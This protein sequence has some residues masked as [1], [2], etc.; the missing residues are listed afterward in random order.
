MAKAKEEKVIL[1]IVTLRE[2][3]QTRTLST[4][5]LIEVLS[6]KRVDVATHWQYRACFRKIAPDIALGEEVYAL[7]ST[8]RRR[9]DLGVA[10]FMVPSTIP[11]Y[12]PVDDMKWPPSTRLAIMAP[13]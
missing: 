9:G 10:M 5:K 2:L 4:R 6:Q 8:R 11:L 12:M 13:D 3:G 1:D 7:G